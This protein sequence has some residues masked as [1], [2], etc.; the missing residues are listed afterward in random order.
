MNPIEVIGHRGYSAV[1]PE[2]TLVS[3]EAALTAGAHAVEFDLHVARCGTPILFHD[4]RLE[5]TTDGGGLVAEQTLEQLRGL[6]AGTWFSTEFAGERIP[7]FVE[8]LELLDGR[9][10][11]LYPEVK[12]FRRPEDVA[13][14]VR[15][16]RDRNLLDHTTFISIDWMALD[17]VRAEEPAVGIGFIV[18]SP[19]QFAEALARAAR[20]PLAILDLSHEVA[21]ADPSV[22]ERACAEGLEVATWTVND[23]EEATVLRDAGVTRFTT[24]QV[25]RIVS[26]AR[27]VGG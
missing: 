5:R 17:H 13:H 21:L 27:S 10:D 15:A 1:A 23:P 18:V 25:D 9:V 24:D 7:S 14:I 12:R 2:N 19:D 6:D 20:D 16:V 4:E 8:A 22:V 11:H 26:W 3:L